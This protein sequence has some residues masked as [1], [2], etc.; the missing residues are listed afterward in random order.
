MPR[1]DYVLLDAD[2]T[3]FDF[4][5]AEH[6][7]L[8]RAMTERGYEFTEEAE[9]LYLSINRALWAAFDRGEVEQKWLVVERFR[10]FDGPTKS[11]IETGNF[12]FPKSSFSGTPFFARPIT[13]KT[14]CAAG[15]KSGCL[16]RI[17]DLSRYAV[18]HFHR[19]HL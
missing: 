8:K 19:Q 18:T 1:F 15:I 3:L 10:R 7:A 16:H 9:S 14:R 6:E 4:D 12:S 13:Y 11:I 5:R 2:N 17:S